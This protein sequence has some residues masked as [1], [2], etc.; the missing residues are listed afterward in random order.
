RAELDTLGLQVAGIHIGLDRL[1][2][3]LD[4]ALADVRALGAQYV[5][6]PFLPPE[7]RRN[8]EDYRTLARTLNQIGRASRDQGLQ[9]CYHNHDFEFQRFGDATGLGIL[10]DETDPELV[11]AELDVYWAAFVGVD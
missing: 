7:R 4:A 5:V 11:K 1:E 3:Q 9:L 8:A 10:F 6:C 2:Q